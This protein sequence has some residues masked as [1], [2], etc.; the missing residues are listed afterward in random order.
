MRTQIGCLIV[1]AVAWT[2]GCGGDGNQAPSDAQLRD[3]LVPSSQV[4][5]YKFHRGYIWNDP[6]DYVAQGIPLSENTLPSDVVGAIDDAGFVKGAGEELRLG[7]I[8]PQ[9][10]LEALKFKSDSGANDARDRL[11][12]EDRKQPCYGVCSQVQKDMA[13]T[14]IPGA[15]GEASLP[16]PNAGPEAPTPFQGYAVTFTVGPYLY[17]VWGG[18][19]VG[20]L[21]LTPLAPG[22]GIKQSILDAADALYQR[23]KDKGD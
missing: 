9:M 19:P 13:V 11:H 14:N 12:L 21:G 16:D 17:Y 4:K 6:I 2:S 23:V 7:T 1:I 20:G 3:R 18:G 15:Q 5:G 8:G 22:G 10:T